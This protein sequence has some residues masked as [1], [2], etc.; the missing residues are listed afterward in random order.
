[1]LSGEQHSSKKISTLSEQQG[2]IVSVSHTLQKLQK[3][4]L[5]IMTDKQT[6]RYGNNVLQK[7][8]KQKKIVFITDLACYLLTITML[9]GSI[10]QTVLKIINPNARRIFI[11]LRIPLFLRCHHMPLNPSCSHYFVKDFKRN[12]LKFSKKNQRNIWKKIVWQPIASVYWLWHWH[13]GCC[14]PFLI[15]ISLNKIFSFCFLFSW[16]IT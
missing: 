6:V 5:W 1:M 10:R 4:M 7:K 11:F 12:S 14:F 9:A 3:Q 15:E 2:I 8:K 16:K 13:R